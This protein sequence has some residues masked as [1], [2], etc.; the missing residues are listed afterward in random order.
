[1]LK[2]ASG[3][4]GRIKRITMQ[5]TLLLPPWPAIPLVSNSKVLISYADCHHD[6]QRTCSGLVPSSV[7]TVSTAHCSAY[8]SFPAF[9]AC[10]AQLHRQSVHEVLIALYE[11]V[12]ERTTDLGL[13]SFPECPALPASAD[14]RPLSLLVLPSLS[15][16][17]SIFLSLSCLRVS[18][19]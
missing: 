13:A 11:A 1:M 7:F 15:E 16:S 19:T 6:V 10:R 5:I 9:K 17:L 14:P 3:K 18:L 12:T 4:K 2:P 8:A